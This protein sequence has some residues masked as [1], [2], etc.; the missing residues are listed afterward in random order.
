MTWILKEKKSVKQD[1]NHQLEGT[2]N[3]LKGNQ[4]DLTN[5]TFEPRFEGGGVSYI[6]LGKSDTSRWSRLEL[7]V[8]SSNL[9]NKIV[10]FIKIP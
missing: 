3:F 5:K 7:H 8:I 1:K 10:K 2:I 6:Y 9:G 4:E